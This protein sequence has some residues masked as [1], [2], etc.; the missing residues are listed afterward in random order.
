MQFLPVLA[1]LGGCT[2]NLVTSEVNVDWDDAKLAAAKIENLGNKD[3]GPFL[4]YF[5][6]DENPESQKRRPQVRHYVPGPGEGESI[7][8]QG[9]FA[10]LSHPQNSN[11]DNIYQI[12][13]YTDPMGMVD[14]SNENDNVLSVPL[15]CSYES[16]DITAGAAGDIVIGQSFNEIRAARVTVVSS[17]DRAIESISL[18]GLNL[19]GGDL[20][21]WVCGCIA[22]ARNS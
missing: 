4:V 18:K 16:S 20:P 1:V 21:W 3:A 22:R 15:D 12:T 7:T 5:D 10:P 19:P 9:D 8:L 2:A 11:L 6:G 13:V 14:E 17:S